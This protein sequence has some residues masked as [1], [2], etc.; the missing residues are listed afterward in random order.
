MP[1]IEKG[2]NILLRWLGVAGIEL[3]KGKE[4]LLI[5]PFLSRPPL[6]F[7]F[8][9][10]AKPDHDLIITHIPQAEYVLVSH[11]HYDHLMDVPVIALH[12]SAQIYGSVN[13][14]QILRIH[15]IPENQI[16]LIVDGDKFSAGD[17]Y[18]SVLPAK[19]PYAPGYTSG[20]L[21]PNLAPPLQLRDYRMDSCYSFLIKAG[22]LQILV[23][24]SISTNSAQPADILFLRAAA[25]QDWYAELLTKVK[26][27]L[28]I[29]THWDNIFQP[30]S[31][32]TQ[33]FFTPPVLSLPPIRRINL[34]DFKRKIQSIFPHCQVLIPQIFKWYDLAKESGIF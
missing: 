22:G 2:K 7:I 34:D 9:G 30:L 32:S 14:C 1:P 11:S 28:V 12:T 6:R 29:P 10:R 19:H 13:T 8:S 5:D 25:D 15:R 17:F 27:K 23:W 4:T 3:H 24:S 21:K 26:P 16:H 18:V 31:K 33:P 20:H